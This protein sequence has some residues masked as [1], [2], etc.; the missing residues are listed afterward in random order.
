[1]PEIALSNIPLPTS[2]IPLSGRTV[3]AM[4]V[5]VNVGVCIKILIAFLP[6][7]EHTYTALRY[8]HNL[9]IRDVSKFFHELHTICNFADLYTID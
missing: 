9:H 8:T 6:Q 7:W 2:S 1:M 3:L 5:Y 4:L